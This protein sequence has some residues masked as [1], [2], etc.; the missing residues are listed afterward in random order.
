MN[1]S[2]VKKVRE[3]YESLPS[4]PSLELHC[5]NDILLND[6]YGVF[7]WDDSNERVIVVNTS[8]N[9]HH[10]TTDEFT[11]TA[12]EYDYIQYIRMDCSARSV[13]KVAQAL[14]FTSTELEE[15]ERFV[16]VATTIEL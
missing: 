1:A 4:R 16:K 14:G 5:D 6:R 2:T 7:H 8:E 9:A 15:L 13:S 10:S 3:V 11:V 12:T